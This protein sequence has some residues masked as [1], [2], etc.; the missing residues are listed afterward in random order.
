MTGL[1]TLLLLE[2][3]DNSIDHKGSKHEENTGQHPD[4]N[5][6]ETLCLGTVG[7]YIVED[8]DQD[9]EEGDEERHPAGDNV[10]GDEEADPGDKDEET[11]GKIVRDDVR[12]HMARQVLKQNS[13]L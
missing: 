12:H 10:R 1:K 11:G 13:S 5:G 4:L 2:I 9:K 7:V 3:K 6:G 8:V